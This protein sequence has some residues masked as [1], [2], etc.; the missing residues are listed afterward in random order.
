MLALVEIEIILAR[1]LVRGIGSQ[2]R[3]GCFLIDWETLTIISVHRCT[4]GKYNAF[5][6]SLAHSLTN[7]HRANEVALMGPY[8]IINRSLD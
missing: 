1:Q 7:V 4:R 3:F 5:D 6:F 8:R 2:W